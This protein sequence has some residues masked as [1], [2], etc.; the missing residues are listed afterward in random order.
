MEEKSTG[1]PGSLKKKNI[2]GVFNDGYF[3]PRLELS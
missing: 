2:L 3:V 1:D